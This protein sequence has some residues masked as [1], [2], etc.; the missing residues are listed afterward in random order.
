M[1]IDACAI[2]RRDGKDIPADAIE[3]TLQEDSCVSL[4]SNDCAQGVIEMRRVADDVFHLHCEIEATTEF[5]PQSISWRFRLP[6]RDG[7]ILQSN[8]QRQK[9]AKS[10]THVPWTPLFIQG[11]WKSKFVSLVSS[12]N[13]LFVEFTNSDS[14]LL[15]T[16]WMDHVNSHPRFTF[17]GESF[18]EWTSEYRYRP[19]KSIRAD[20]Y[21][22]ISDQPIAVPVLGRYPGDFQAVMSISDHADHDSCAK[23]S[24]LLYGSSEAETAK[25]I[26]SGFAT[27]QLPFTKSIFPDC[28]LKDG[29]SILE[30]NFKK[31]C[32]QAHQANIEICPHGIHQSN[33]NPENAA[34][35]LRPF[36]EF[37]P[38]T[39]IDHGT[40]YKPCYFNSG[41]DP[42]SQHYLIPHLERLGIR[43]I[44]GFVNFLHVA[45]G[46][47]LDMLRVR[48]FTAKPL[49]KSWPSTLRQA[50]QTYR[51]WTVPNAL[52]TFLFQVMPEASYDEYWEF[53]RAALNVFWNKKISGTPKAG[54]QFAK[55]FASMLK[56]ESRR[57][58][59]SNLFHPRPEVAAGPVLFQ[60]HNGFNNNGPWWLFNTL[61]INDLG[62]EY[63]PANVDRLIDDHGLHFGHTYLGSTSRAHLSNA[64]IVDSNGESRLEPSFAKNLQHIAKRRNENKLWVATTQMVNDHLVSLRQVSLVPI[65]RNKWLLKS[66][67]ASSV[68]VQLFFFDSDGATK[69]DDQSAQ[70]GRFRDGA[71]RTAISV[72]PH[73]EVTIQS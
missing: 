14:Q 71:V 42:Q 61:T 41:Q 22:L 3:P 19:G 57:S 13:D 55:L 36:E 15:F 60:E 46:G 32:V 9:I 56:K 28:K 50:M 63:R 40:L 33:T 2:I 18:R 59:W 20:L 38:A 23:F 49:L 12:G 25:R 6:L 26:N 17:A 27:L 44:W 72:A 35:L 48:G 64:L 58:A 10:N 30:P 45:P 16:V 21:L 24:A 53:R 54:I 29:P 62:N 7:K 73:R 47:Q 66:K 31:L 11:R 65:A 8:Y 70:V 43:Y 34:E 4:W 69:I 51:P 37:Q 1:A 68:D 52:S 5:S 67:A 39:W